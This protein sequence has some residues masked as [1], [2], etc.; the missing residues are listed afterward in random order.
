MQSLQAFAFQRFVAEFDA[1]KT[2]Y[3]DYKRN[4]ALLD[5][6]DLLHHASDLLKSNETVRQALAKRYPVILVDEFQDTD[7]LQAEIV[8]RL[9]GEG[10][11]SLP[12][13]ER[14]IRP[15]AL[16]VV[17]DPKQAVYRFRG[18]DVETYLVAK[19]ALAKQ[20]PKAI[21]DVSAN[22]RSQPAILEFVNTHFSALLDV[23]QGQ[24]GFTAL[25]P[26]RPSNHEPSVAAFEI[27]LG[28]KHK[29]NGE[30]KVDLVRI[31]EISI[32]ADIV[33]GLIGS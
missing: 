3:R 5:F 8:W 28:D 1:L 10:D 12:W 15:G 23:S 14:E 31:E 32:V 7:P 26:V 33:H 24:P 16:F 22:F 13:H 11:P 29:P 6:D 2:L 17:G 30:L 18:A 25:T 4:A 9:A 19:R 21:L 27:A 20:D